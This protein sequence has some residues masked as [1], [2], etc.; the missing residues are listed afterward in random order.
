MAVDARDDAAD[1]KAQ[2][3][4]LGNDAE[5]RL[6]GNVVA[7]ENRAPAAK[8]CML[9]QLYHR[10]RLADARRLD[11]DNG[12]AGQ[13]LDR[14]GGQLV[15]YGDDRRLQRLVLEDPTL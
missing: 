10:R 13:H 8:W 15:A 11:L 1:R 5:H 9:H 14:A 3:A 12:F 4:E 2:A 7:N 6:I